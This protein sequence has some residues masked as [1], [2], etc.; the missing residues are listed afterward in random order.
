MS[1]IAG[2]LTAEQFALLPDPESGEQME[3]VRGAVVMAPPPP[4]GHGHRARR[5]ERALEDFVIRN[6][7][8]LTSGE[9]GYRLSRDPDTVRAPDS[10]WVAFDRLPNAQFPEEDYPD[11]APNLAVEVV[12]RSDRDSDVLDKVD[13]YFAAGAD[14]VWVVRPRQRT[15]TVHR[16]NGDAHTYRIGDTLSSDE[17]G[18]PLAGFAL[19]IASIFE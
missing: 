3:L 1:T 16:P 15:V 17:A 11:T 4:A 13:D 19:S 9:G 2:T 12:S 6:R 7:L 5:I 14:R 10:A 8:G 18:F